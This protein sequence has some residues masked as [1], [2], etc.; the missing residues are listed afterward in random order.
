MTCRGEPEDC[1]R[2]RGSGLRNKLMKLS[3]DWVRVRMARSSCR[4]T[5]TNSNKT[6]MMP[7]TLSLSSRAM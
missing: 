6:M 5:S 3:N 2:K 4:M 1:R 7:K